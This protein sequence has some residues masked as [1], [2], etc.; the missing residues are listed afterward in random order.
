MIEVFRS[1][2]ARIKKIAGTCL[3]AAAFAAAG[4]SPAYAWWNEEWTARKQL[5]VDASVTGADINETLVD[6]PIL[7]RLHTGN[8]GFF[9]DVAENGKDLRFVGG[10]QVPFKFHIDKID[11]I[12]EMAFI[13]VKIPQVAGGSASEPVWMYYGNPEAVAAE[14]AGGTYGVN[15]VAVYHFGD[16]LATDATAYANH[17]TEATAIAEP[18]GFI[19]SAARF[20]GGDLIVLGLSESLALTPT[21]GWS[22]SAWVKVEDQASES[23]ILQAGEGTASVELIVQETGVL[24]RA[25]TP[26]GLRST[27]AQPIQKNAWQHLSVDYNGSRLA[28]YVAGE[29]VA[30]TDAA[31]PAISAPILLGAG[32]DGRN[33][34]GLLDEV[35]I[36][37]VSRPPDWIKALARSQGVD[38]TVL[39]FGGDES[40]ESDQSASYFAIILSNLT[41]DGWVIIGLLAVMFCISMM[42]MVS[43]GVIISRIKKDNRLFMT[44]FRQLGQGDPAALDLGDDESDA[45]IEDSAMLLALFGKHDNYQS[46][47]LYHIYH[48]GIQ[49]IKQRKVDALRGLSPE[50][51][52]VIR[53]HLEAALSHEYHR[54]NKQLVLLTIAISGGPF[55]GLLGTVVGV[56][57]T[58]AAIAATGDVNINAIAPGIS[59]ALMATVAGL[60]VA[61][62]CLFGYNYLLTQIKELTAEMRIFADELIHRIAETS[63]L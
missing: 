18:A 35:Q 49:E 15:Q 10:D 44:Q 29:K 51:L 53:V 59:A 3:I 52:A 12:N 8:F 60:V 27:S 48:A 25:N 39:S 11:V 41:I 23:V 9:L 56:M 24:L 55:L 40:N 61:I 37:N 33:F 26:E 19:G 58:F 62:P 34:K 36:S 5:T 28:L 42:V 32:S 50:A 6:F 16:T 21:T 47:S 57:I 31:L 54:L 46:S 14:D 45:E 2:S 30:E 7:V 63:K 20:R 13:W 22:F 43:K 38:S 4:N 1:R 17:A